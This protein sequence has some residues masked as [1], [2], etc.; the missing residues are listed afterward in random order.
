MM[1]LARSGLRHNVL[2][3][4][5]TFS[6]ELKSCNLSMLMVYS[7]ESNF[8]NSK[9]LQ[10]PRELRDKILGFVIGDNLIH[11][12]RCRRPPRQPYANREIAGFGRRYFPVS[13]TDLTK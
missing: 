7:M 4:K 1:L 11:V 6:I 9:L 10:L 5:N 8:E 12:H 2:E 13:Q 3:R